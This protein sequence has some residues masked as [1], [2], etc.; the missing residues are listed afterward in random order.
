MIVFILGCRDEIFLQK[1]LFE[2]V[3]MAQESIGVA[4]IFDWGG[5]K[6]QITCSDVIKNFQKRNLLWDKGIVKWKI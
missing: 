5:T 3:F 1:N 4:R 2:I 6:P